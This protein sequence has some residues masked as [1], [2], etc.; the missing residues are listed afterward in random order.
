MFNLEKESLKEIL[1][2]KF[3]T[4][5]KA[6]NSR[7]VRLREVFQMRGTGVQGISLSMGRRAD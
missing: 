2:Q 4:G 5:E 7:G 1:L 3:G 6:F